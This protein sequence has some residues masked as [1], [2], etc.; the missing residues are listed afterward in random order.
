M[1]RGLRISIAED[2]VE[3]QEY[4]LTMLPRLG[5]EVC[6]VASTGTQLVAQ[7][8]RMRPDLVITDIKMEGLDGIDAASEIY[9]ESPLP[10]ILISAYHDRE[11]MQRV[12]ADFIQAFLVKPIKIEELAP[13]I[14]IAYRRF[15]EFQ[16]L[17]RETASLRQALED[18]KLIER[19]K[20]LMMKKTGLDE[21]AAFR[22][23][24]K[25][26][27]EKNLKLVRLAESILTADEAFGAESSPA[28]DSRG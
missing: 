25:L 23:M 27:S 22:R 3:M 24:Q 11:L 15:E 4:L 9:R 13:A 14:A 26:A 7:V 10:V 16:T 5:H 12:E 19:A 2:E 17:Q 8:K 21:E 20:G 28:A 6:S 1:G 18:R